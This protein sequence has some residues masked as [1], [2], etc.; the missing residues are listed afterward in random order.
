M[1]RLYTLFQ[2]FLSVSFQFILGKKKETELR[3]QDKRLKSTTFKLKP[4]KSE[5]KKDKNTKI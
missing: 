2:E 1:K 3:L 5:E 4:L